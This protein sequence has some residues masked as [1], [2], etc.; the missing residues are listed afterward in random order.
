MFCNIRSI[1][2]QWITVCLR[3]EH[4]EHNFLPHVVKVVLFLFSLES[5]DIFRDPLKFM[6]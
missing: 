6:Y 2:I 1:K 3:T 5:C 4:Y